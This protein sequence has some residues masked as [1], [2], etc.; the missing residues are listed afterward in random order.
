MPIYSE[1]KSTKNNERLQEENAI[2]NKNN[3]KTI[4]FYWILL[5]K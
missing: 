2:T 1:D 4:L 3:N 5:R